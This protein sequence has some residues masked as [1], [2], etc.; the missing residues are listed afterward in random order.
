MFKF[1]RRKPKAEADV[2]SETNSKK[3]DGI[4]EENIGDDSNNTLDNDKIGI[5]ESS[6]NTSE[7]G[8]PIKRLNSLDS[9]IVVDKV[10]SGVEYAVVQKKKTKG[11]VPVKKVEAPKKADNENEISKPSED[12][13]QDNGKITE[14]KSEPLYMNGTKDNQEFVYINE[15]AIDVSGLPDKILDSLPGG[16]EDNVGSDVTSERS[17]TEA[18]VQ[19]IVSSD[20]AASSGAKYKVSDKTKPEKPKLKKKSWSFQVMGKK[21]KR[22]S[23]EDEIETD[24][25]KVSMD[26]SA[27][28]PPETKKSKWLF[29]MFSF[30]RGSDDMT[31]S[32]PNL[33]QVGIPEE[34]EVDGGQVKSRTKLKKKGKDKKSKSPKKDVT[35]LD[36]RSTSL[37]DIVPRDSNN[38]RKRRSIIEDDIEYTPTDAFEGVTLSDLSQ[39][40]EAETEVTMQPDGNSKNVKEKH[41]KKEKQGKVKT[42]V[43]TEV[44]KVP[45]VEKVE[46]ESFTGIKGVSLDTV[47]VGEANK[48]IDAS[49]DDNKL[50][51][52]I[53]EDEYVSIVPDKHDEIERIQI[54]EDEYAVVTKKK[55]EAKKDIDKSKSSDTV[56]DEE[57]DTALLKE[58]GLEQSQLTE[59]DK[60]VTEDV[61]V[62]VQNEKAF[63][64]L[65]YSDE[66]FNASLIKISAKAGKTAIKNKD[67]EIV[68]VTPTAEASK[69]V[70]EEY[71]EVKSEIAELQ[72][73]PVTS[74]EESA[75]ENEI[76][77]KTEELK[78]EPSENDGDVS[79][80]V[81]SKEE[82]TV[83]ESAITQSEIKQDD[84]EPVVQ[85]EEE[86]CAPEVEPEAVILPEVERTVTTEVKTIVLKDVGVQAPDI[87]MPLDI[88]VDFGNTTGKVTTV[89]IGVQ[90][91][92]NELDDVNHVVVTMETNKEI[93]KPSEA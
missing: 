77:E 4:V 39:D 46:D 43:E 25:N 79:D 67:E 36:K 17:G 76:K 59:N 54:N 93:Q 64:N 85:T 51:S 91:D 19:S 21:D 86:S 63:S 12:T 31:S 11:L 92:G 28:P 87:H 24:S 90:V 20:S 50:T 35:S 69:E 73:E 6:G 30:R 74:Q 3:I 7:D 14:D 68:T 60:E 81:I 80:T 62:P 84:I 82:V 57:N 53:I 29:G 47:D 18:E 10:T 22:G 52:E 16:K 13:K 41:G 44:Q 34:Q 48:S 1:S 55:P 49:V 66:E 58:Y 56:T 15:R 71:V 89:S 33:Q 61:M 32:T 65:I 26:P 40:E 72:A 2:S 42:P 27:S 8:T 45:D 9:G 78:V 5:G 23:N 75:T 37:M 83:V 70:V 38:S 88:N